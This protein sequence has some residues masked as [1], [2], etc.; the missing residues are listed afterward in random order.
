MHLENIEIHKETISIFIGSN[1]RVR[2][3]QKKSGN[4]LRCTENCH[5]KCQ[6]RNTFYLQIFHL[7]RYICSRIRSC[8]V[9]N[10]ALTS[11]LEKYHL[12]K[13]KFSH[14][15][16]QLS[17][18]SELFLIDLVMQMW[19]IKSVWSFT[20]FDFLSYIDEITNVAKSKCQWRYQATIIH[21]SKIWMWMPERVFWIHTSVLMRLRHCKTSKMW[22]IVSK[23]FW[24]FHSICKKEF[25]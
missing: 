14:D 10:F 6:C 11:M 4:N 23:L 3:N 12:F 9:V 8:S 17:Y 7:V 5:R 20:S 1:C 19:N 24:F 22:K 21:T 18:W 13:W 16:H 2:V 15:S 25:Q